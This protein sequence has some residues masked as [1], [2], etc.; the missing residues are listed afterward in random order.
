MTP[1]IWRVVTGL[2]GRLLK[3]ANGKVVVTGEENVVIADCRND[4]LVEGDQRHNAEV[5]ALLPELLEVLRQAEA[6][7]GDLPSR[8]VDD[9]TMELHARMALL[10]QNA[11]VT[12]LNRDE[13]WAA[14]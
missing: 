8:C 1:G 12:P 10:M 4:E 7:F 6:T 14:D 11:G 5:I 3:S 9:D 13:R 2:T